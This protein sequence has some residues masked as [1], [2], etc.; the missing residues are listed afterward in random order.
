MKVSELIQ[1]LLDIQHLAGEDIEIKSVLFDEYL[2]EFK[3]T[4][5][6]LPILMHHPDSMDQVCIL[7]MTEDTNMMPE[8]GSHHLIRYLDESWQHGKCDIKWLP[9]SERNA[10][11]GCTI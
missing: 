8:K 4:S 5:V 7:G 3:E 9:W 1:S 11:N 2:D 6:L 10:I